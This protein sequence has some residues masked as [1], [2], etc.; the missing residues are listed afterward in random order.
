M[1]S[2]VA[3]L[4]R[5]IPVCPEL[6]SGVRDLHFLPLHQKREPSFLL[7]NP[8]LGI[9]SICIHSFSKYVLSTNSPETVCT[10]RGTTEGSFLRKGLV[11][12]L[13]TLSL[14]VSM[15][16]Y[17]LVPNA[18]LIAHFHLIFKDTRRV[19]KGLKALGSLAPFQSLFT[20]IVL[21]N[22]EVQQPY[23]PLSTLS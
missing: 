5:K 13:G 1:S 17:P 18:N 10:G 8:S 7:P 11:A 19:Q 21:R 15:G 9:S 2:V 22:Q 20:C 16:L 3:L 23:K 14:V 12:L 4:G 6:Q